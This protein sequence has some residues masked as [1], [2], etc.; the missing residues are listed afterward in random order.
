MRDEPTIFEVTFTVDADPPVAWKAL[1]GLQ[2]GRVDEHATPRRWWLPGFESTGTEVAAAPGDR[3]TVR[4]DAFP[5][6]GTLIAIT[7]EHTGT[8]SRV[9]VTQSGF[10]EAFVRAAGEGFWIAAEQIA[11]DLRLFFETGVL[12]G[13]HGRP[14]AFLGCDAVE[15]PLGIEVT[16][17]ADG[18]WAARAGLAPGDVLLTIAGAPLTALRDFVTVQRV[19]APGADVSA[20]WARGGQRI[21]ATATL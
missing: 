15:T 13:R 19:V 18:T 12:G 1:E 17:V 2:V 3:L 7:F 9:T 10:D 5:C 16:G 8:G 14:W 21:E 4:K 20:T 11:A 6:E